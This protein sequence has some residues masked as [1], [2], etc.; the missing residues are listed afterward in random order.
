[1]GDRGPHHHHGRQP[2]AEGRLSHRDPGYPVREPYN[3]EREAHRGDQDRWGPGPSSY[4]DRRA[5]PPPPGYSYD[6]RGRAV[7]G[8]AGSWNPP[9]GW[10]PPPGPSNRPEP[11]RGG[12][13]GP[14]RHDEG[15]GYYRDDMPRR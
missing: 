7:H 10:G 9:P 1:M 6:G 8:P 13:L 4:H 2:G 15:R 3:P 12:P 5:P 14:P 11:P